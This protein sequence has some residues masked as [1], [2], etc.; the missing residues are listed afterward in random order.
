[1][2]P[3]QPDIRGILVLTQLVNLIQVA[4][5]REG[6]Q[7]SKTCWQS[8]IIARIQLPAYIRIS[9]VHP[10]GNQSW[11]FIGR[12]DVEAETLILQPLMQRTDLLEKILMLGNIERGRRRLRHR[13][14]WSV[15][16]P[17]WW[18]WVWVNSVS[19]W[20]TGRPG[21]LQSM[22]LQRV[23]HDWVIELNWTEFWGL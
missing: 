19:W 20:R 9:P 1:M 8:S 22:G 15:A 4:F 23:R 10:K 2:I 21:M 17:T 5:S 3:S 7:P 12:I 11:I 6:P 18:T 16:S 14:R 13:M